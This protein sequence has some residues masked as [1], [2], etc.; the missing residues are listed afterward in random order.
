MLLQKSMAA[1]DAFGNHLPAHLARGNLR[2]PISFSL[3]YFA[4]NPLNTTP[5][6]FLRMKI[7]SVRL[8]RRA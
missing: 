8:A 3:A 2:H 7:S 1:R 4:P 5:T 6:V